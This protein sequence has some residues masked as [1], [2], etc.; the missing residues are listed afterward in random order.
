M[1]DDGSDRVQE[2]GGAREERESES[3]REI[4]KS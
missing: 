2:A 3:E 4:K 1:T